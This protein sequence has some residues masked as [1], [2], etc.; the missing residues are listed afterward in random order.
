MRATVGEAIPGPTRDSNPPACI[1]EYSDI[2]KQYYNQLTVLPD[3]V[4]PWPHPVAKSDT[5]IILIEHASVP[6]TCNSR[7]DTFSFMPPV[8]TGMCVLQYEDI[9]TCDGGS[10]LTVLIDGAPGVGKTTLCKRIAQNWSKGVVPALNHYQI[11]LLVHLREASNTKDVDDLFNLYVDHKTTCR[12]VIE[13]VKQNSGKQIMLLLDGFDE[14]P[15]N[16]RSDS[17]FANL[18]QGKTLVNCAIVVTSRPYATLDLQSLRCFSRH[19]GVQGFTPNQIKDCIYAA[20]P[21]EVIKAARLMEDL[22]RRED[23]L[24]LC[25]VPMNCAIIIAVYKGEECCLPLRVTELYKMFLTHALRRHIKKNGLQIEFNTLEDL[26]GDLLSNV[27]TLAKIA[28]D[29]L[30][31]DKLVFSKRDLL[32]KSGSQDEIHMMIMGLVTAFNGVSGFGPTQHFQFLH[33]TIQEFLAAWHALTLSSEEQAG[34]IGN[35]TNERLMLMRLFLAGLS[36]L[37]DPIVCKALN[38]IEWNFCMGLEGDVV[39]NNHVFAEHLHMIYESQNSKL[40]KCISDNVESRVLRLQYFP[41]SPLTY[42]LLSFFLLHSMC[43]WEQVDFSGLDWNISLLN[44]FNDKVEPPTSVKGL[45]LFDGS[46]CV[47]QSNITLDCLTLISN[48]PIFKSLESLTIA[49]LPLKCLGANHSLKEMLEM[50]QLNTLSFIE[51]PYLNSYEYRS[52]NTHEL[53]KLLKE[54]PALSDS[55]QD[56]KLSLYSFDYETMRFLGE[57]LVKSKVRTLQLCLNST[58]HSLDDGIDRVPEGIAFLMPYIIKMKY[59]ESL[60][61]ILLRSPHLLFSVDDEL[62][63]LRAL[64]EPTITFKKLELCILPA[65]HSDM[66]YI[67]SGLEV[68]TS[69]SSLVIAGD[70]TFDLHIL[71]SIFC[72]LR[73]NKILQSLHVVRSSSY[74]KV[75]KKCDIERTWIAFSNFL[76]GNTVYKKL[77]FM[78]YKGRQCRALQLAAAILPT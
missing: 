59:L 72:A 21:G 26:Q 45:T 64:L 66:E 48:I 33:L 8:G 47:R 58:E 32:S 42:R 1:K 14:L 41:N 38:S 27:D 50:R 63:Q 35:F 17:V 67:C 53:G 56:L 60:S 4:I 31:T 22:E 43:A 19:L 40:C 16:L 12:N 65:T 73:T 51:L 5:Q 18:I 30:I 29:F 68:N 77:N 20:F 37:K 78:M 52:L 25:H 6:A 28:Y 49:A 70:L 2:L 61:I 11:V 44:L 74:A 46:M 76:M 9:F 62:S 23:I 54:A 75:E 55:L 3:D 15:P 10:K 24:S 69:I 71:K 36:K 7:A 39:F 13:I 34:I 57:G